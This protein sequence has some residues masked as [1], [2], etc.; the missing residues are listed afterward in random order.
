M[1]KITVLGMGAMGSRMALSLIKAEHEVTVWNRSIDRTKTVKDAG[2]KIAYTPREAVKDAEFVI[3]MVRDN[4]ASKD[5]WL[6]D[7]GALAGMNKKTIAIESSTLTVAWIKELNKH[8]KQQEIAFIDAPVAGTRPQ[9]EAAQLIYFVGGDA[10]IY[11]RAKPILQAMG[12]KIN[13]V[14]DVGSGMAVKLAVNS[15]FAIQVS[16]MAELVNLMH[17]SGLDEAQAIEILADTP[18]CSPAAAT[19]GKAIAA[20]KFAPLFPIELVEKDLNYALEISNAD[21][22]P[23]INTTQR[24]YAK[25]IERG[26]GEDNITGVA[27]LY[28]RTVNSQ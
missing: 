2:A 6:S 19:A 14:G 11:D 12:S 13:H 25:A 28:R 3:S 8:F 20:Q 16:T 1:A 18:V 5:V 21:N 4:A 27:Q 17:Q 10:A 24:I 26:Y 15:L 9:A 22:L 7:T 23:L